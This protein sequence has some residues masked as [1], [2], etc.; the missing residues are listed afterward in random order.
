MIGEKSWLHPHT[1]EG[2]SHLVVLPGQ[3]KSYLLS[4]KKHSMM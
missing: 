4:V 2:V 3:G 1:A